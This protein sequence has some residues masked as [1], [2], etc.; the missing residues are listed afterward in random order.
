MGEDWTGKRHDASNGD[1]HD[2]RDP[3]D[4]LSADELERQAREAIAQ[5]R[6][7]VGDFGGRVRRV[8]ERAG[9]HWEASAA[10]PQSTQVPISAGERARA[11]ARRW[12]DI[13]FLVD[14]DLAAG[15]SVHALEERA[16]WR[17]EV[18]ERGETR[19]LDERIEAYRGTHAPDEHPPLPVWDYSFP[20]T[21][22][23]E[24]GERRERVPGAGS[25]QACAQCG[26]SGHRAC[27]GCEG[28]GTQICPHCHG[29]GRL[30]CAR[31]RG[32]GQIEASSGARP[33]LQDATHLQAHAERLLN[34]AGERINFLRDRLHDEWQARTNAPQSAQ[35]SGA[36]AA[37]LIPCPDCEGG[38]IA[39][40]CDGGRRTCAICGGIGQTECAACKG[41]GRVVYHREVV[42]R[43]DTRVGRRTLTTLSTDNA[44]DDA[45]ADWAPEDVLARGAVEPVWEGPLDG[46]TATPRPPN[47][48]EDLWQAALAFAA[49]HERAPVA[50]AP[51]R[52]PA[53]GEERRVIQRRLALVRLPMIRVEYTLAEK[54]YVFVAYGRDGAERFWAERFPHRWSR[55]GRFLRAISRDL[56]EQAQGDQPPPGKVSTLFERRVRIGDADVTDPADPAASSQSPRADNPPMGDREA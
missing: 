51:E 21:P 13:D 14:P 30:V 6:E 7:R 41:S 3:H 4:G 1:E 36:N 2:Q 20:A 23:I 19:S 32:R 55:V 29:R 54:P 5:I 18:R 38:T 37:H 53:P 48:P 47:V 15:L 49:I 26:G 42:R 28:S 52:S 24:A 46:V 22:E 39:C 56:S 45:S 35:P 25:I 16:I 31:C 34:E 27:A 44:H 43:F 17:A 12:A 8:I 40:D 11:L 10:I 50:G 33:S 9:V